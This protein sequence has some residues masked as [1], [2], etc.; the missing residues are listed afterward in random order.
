MKE[1]E[2]ENCEKNEKL[3]VECEQKL[4]NFCLEQNKDRYKFPTS[5]NMGCY[6]SSSYYRCCDSYYVYICKDCVKQLNESIK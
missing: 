4:C 2:V 1:L 5:F 6:C 3:E